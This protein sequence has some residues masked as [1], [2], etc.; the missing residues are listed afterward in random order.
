MSQLPCC[1][2]GPFTS[3]RFL[4]GRPAL[5]FG[6]ESILMIVFFA[7]LLLGGILNNW[8]PAFIKPKGVLGPIFYQRLGT[9][10]ISTTVPVLHLGRRWAWIRPFRERHSP[11]CF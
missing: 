10:M 2:G 11:L 1:S 9:A 4:A 7:C 6:T 3:D 8:S 5:P